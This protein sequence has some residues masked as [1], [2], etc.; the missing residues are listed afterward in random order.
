MSLGWNDGVGSGA[1]AASGR[2][3]AAADDYPDGSALSVTCAVTKTGR[4]GD[5]P[6][7]DERRTLNAE[8]ATPWP[9]LPS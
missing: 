5:G 7:D 6:W 2:C 3:R 4:Y 1:Q 9:V 8:C